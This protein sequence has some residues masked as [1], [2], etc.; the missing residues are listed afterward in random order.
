MEGSQ[1]YVLRHVRE[2]IVCQ[3]NKAKQTHLQVCYIHYPFQ[4]IN[5]MDFIT[6]P[7]K[8][9]DKDYIYVVVDKLSKFAHFY[10]KL[11]SIT[12]GKAIFE[13]SV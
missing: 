4:I 3:Q 5:G 13:G 9:H 2:C 11:I 10:C 12:C 1:G 6:V 7:R 8:V